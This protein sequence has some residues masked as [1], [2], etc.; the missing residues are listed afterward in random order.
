MESEDKVK[1]GRGADPP[2]IA[3]GSKKA[4]TTMGLFGSKGD[5]NKQNDSRTK[6]EKEMDQ[7]DGDIKTRKDN[8]VDRS[9]RQREERMRNSKEWPCCLLVLSCTFQC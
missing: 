4:H 9:H 6:G 5:P 8:K 2:M 7:M 1:E 3:A